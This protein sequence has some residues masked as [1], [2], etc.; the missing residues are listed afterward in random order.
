MS[1]GGLLHGEPTPLYRACRSRAST[2]SRRFKR[3]M[4]QLLELY[5]D[6]FRYHSHKLS[7]VVTHPAYVTHL[8][9]L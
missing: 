7:L 2:K 5:Y 9:Y 8:K 3:R 1:E 6:W 4:E